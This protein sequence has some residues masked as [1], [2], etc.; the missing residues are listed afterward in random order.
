MQ[1]SFNSVAQ[2]SSQNPFLPTSQ[3]SAISKD[4]PQ[5]VSRRTLFFTR[6]LLVEN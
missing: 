4:S 2:L 6:D 3:T 5:T 1:T